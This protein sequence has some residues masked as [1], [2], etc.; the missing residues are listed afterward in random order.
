M[1]D[2]GRKIRPPSLE[3]IPADCPE[4]LRPLIE[5]LIYA[6]DLREGRVGKGT[7]TRFVT[8]QDLVDAAVVADGVIK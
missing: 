3:D 7:N 2:I 8:I 5:Q 1:A 6:I 4:G